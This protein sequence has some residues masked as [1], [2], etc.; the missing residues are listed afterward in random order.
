MSIKKVKSKKNDTTEEAF[1]MIVEGHWKKY[2][3]D[4]NGYLDYE[5]FLV[6]AAAENNMDFPKEDI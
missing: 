3:R 2:D 5:E 1:L 4:S 6:F